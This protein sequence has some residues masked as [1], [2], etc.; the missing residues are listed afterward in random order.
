MSYYCVEGQEEVDDDRICLIPHHCYCDASL[1]AREVRDLV[2]EDKYEHLEILTGLPEVL[3][4]IVAGL[5][6]L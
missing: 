5:T 1:D 6:S 4:R 2:K 3:I